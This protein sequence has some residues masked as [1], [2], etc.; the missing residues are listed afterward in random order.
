VDGQPVVAKQFYMAALVGLPWFR[1][2][3]KGAETLGHLYQETVQAY[4]LENDLSADSRHWVPLVEFTLLGDPELRI[5]HW[6][7]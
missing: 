1:A 6:R 3:R 4:L 2:Y 7:E 5:P